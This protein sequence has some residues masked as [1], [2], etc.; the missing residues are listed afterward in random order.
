MTWANKLVPNVTN[1]LLSPRPRKPVSTCSKLEFS[2]SRSRE[3]LEGRRQEL[4]IE[5]LGEREAL[6]AFTMVTTKRV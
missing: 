1:I 5:L 3:R 2:G 6:S 4:T